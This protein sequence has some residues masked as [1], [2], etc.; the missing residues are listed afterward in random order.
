MC[1]YILRPA[2]VAPGDR[3]ICFE[4]DTIATLALKC[5]KAMRQLIVYRSAK[6]LLTQVIFASLYR[7]V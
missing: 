5:D 2:E 7:F 6:L 4:K 1:F 3:E